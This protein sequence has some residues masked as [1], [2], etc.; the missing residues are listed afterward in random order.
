MLL[1]KISRPGSYPIVR[2]L[3]PLVSA[4]SMSSHRLSSFLITPDE[5]KKARKGRA[6]DSRIVPVSAEWYIPVAGARNGFEEYKKQRIPKARFFDLDAIK[7][8]DS[9]YPHMLPTA[10]T[11]AKAM[12]KLGI[13]R[14]DTVVVYDSPHVGI[15]SGPRAAWTFKVFG[16]ERV[17]LLNNFKEWAKGGYLVERGEPFK[18]PETSYPVVQPDTSLAIDFEEVKQLVQGGL[19]GVQILDARPNKRFTG[20]DP[21]P[22]PGLS[23][24]HIPGS[25][26]V[27]FSYLVSV[28]NNTLKP[29]DELRSILLKAGVDDS[30][31]T[32]TILMC[33][34][35][36]TA[37]VI[38]A[39]ME[40]AGFSGKKRIYDGSWTEWAQRVEEGSGLIVKDE[41]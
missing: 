11:F 2:S 38:E 40:A 8:F 19:K 39:A 33:G 32:D 36:V 27:P 20:V 9:P 15:F 41:Q 29:S 4:Q 26:S 6:G 31:E 3:V 12:S 1:A 34:T 16:H 25:I 18:W 35:G 5:L 22:R 14:E 13:S 37:A 21:E 7:D 23:S 28:S 17:H 10:E 30:P 24:G